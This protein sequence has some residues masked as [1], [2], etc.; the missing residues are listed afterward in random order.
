MGNL[1]RQCSFSNKCNKEWVLTNSLLFRW[2]TRVGLGALE[3]FSSRWHSEMW[4]RAGDTVT[5]P[6]KATAKCAA[7]LCYFCGDAQ[8]MCQCG[9]AWGGRCVHK[10]VIQNGCKSD[11]FVGISVVDMYS[12]CESTLRML[13]RVFNKMPSWDMVPWTTIMLGYL[14]C[15]QGQT[16]LELFWQMN[17]EGV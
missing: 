16:L 7:R 13:W 15:V 6:T 9:C 3:Q 10:Q 5:I 14:K 8:C 4:T 17:Q 2:L 11:V 12:K 1:R